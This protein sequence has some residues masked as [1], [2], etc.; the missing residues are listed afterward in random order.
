MVYINRKLKF[1]LDTE[2]FKRDNQN[3]R[4]RKDIL[5]S[6]SVFDE[7]V[8][9][10]ALPLD[11]IDIQIVDLLIEDG[12]M[13]CAEIA[14]RIGG[15][16]ERMVRYR[17][18][19]MLKEKVIQISAIANPKAIG[20][21]VVADVL[22]E[23]EPAYITEVANQ[24]ANFECVSYVAYSIGNTDVSAQVVAPDNDQVYAFVTQVIGRL[25]GVRKSTTSIVPKVVK[26]VYQWRFPNPQEGCAG[27]EQT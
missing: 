14:R 18:N 5:I 26:D 17:L 22:L 3:S 15:I 11:T 1:L 12:R 9:R 10:Q 24:I 21:T 6:L 19:R 27:D 25:P 13:P 7:S 16:T 2:K 8:S 4:K 20:Y 23:V